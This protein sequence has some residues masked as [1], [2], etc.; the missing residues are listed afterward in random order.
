MFDTSHFCVLI[1]KGHGQH[2]QHCP[3]ADG[4]QQKASPPTAPSAGPSWQ[5][6][7]NLFYTS[8]FF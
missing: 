2:G 1:L 7:N 5:A 8:C 3:L 4:L 6:P